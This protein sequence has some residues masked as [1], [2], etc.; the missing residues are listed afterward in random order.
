[1]PTSEWSVTESL[2]LAFNIVVIGFIIWALRRRIR[3]KLN[4]VEERQKKSLERS[5][6]LEDDNSE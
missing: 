1:M 4:E 2:I 6:Y 3:S 5:K